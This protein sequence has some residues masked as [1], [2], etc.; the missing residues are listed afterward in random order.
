M[1]SSRLSA[2]PSSAIS[3]ATGGEYTS[4]AES[5]IGKLRLKARSPSPS[6]GRRSTA[7]IARTQTTIRQSRKPSGC[8]R[9]SYASQTTSGT[10]ID[11]SRMRKEAA[12]AGDRA[13]SAIAYRLR[14]AQQERLTP[15]FTMHRGDH[16]VPDPHVGDDVT[17]THSLL[18][19]RRD[20]DHVGQEHQLVIR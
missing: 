4:A 2:A 20:C 3:A 13:P 9:N 8:S 11:A 14:D 10:T 5:S 15:P 1:R 12:R 19:R 17:R 16:E 18:D 6:S 7:A